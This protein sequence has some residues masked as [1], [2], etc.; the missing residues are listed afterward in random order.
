VPV[1]VVPSPLLFEVESRLVTLAPL[2][3]AVLPEA[4]PLLV[5]RMPVTVRWPVSWPW[6]LTVV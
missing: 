2:S 5:E 3:W 4:A 6:L 1:R